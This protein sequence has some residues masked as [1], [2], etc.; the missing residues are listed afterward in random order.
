MPITVNEGGTLYEL[1]E[2]WSNESGTLYE[3]DEVCSNEGGTLYEIHSKAEAEFPTELTWDA[4]GKRNFSTFNNGLTAIIDHAL[5]GNGNV[6][7]MATSSEFA[8]KGNVI[9]TIEYSMSISTTGSGGWR[10]YKDGSKIA[11]DGFTANTSKTQSVELTTGNY[12]IDFGAGGGASSGS[13]F[14]SASIRIT[15]SKS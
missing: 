15:F 6:I 3:L 5:T 9:L 13:Y 8:I 4:E 14:G 10:L 7:G 1:D 2:V 12:S 11:G